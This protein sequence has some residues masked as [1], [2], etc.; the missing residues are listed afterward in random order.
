MVDRTPRRVNGLSLTD[1]LN[2]T[3]YFCAFPAQTSHTRT[4]PKSNIC[5]KGTSF[6]LLSHFIHFDDV[7]P[8]PEKFGS[9]GWVL[10]RCVRIISDESE[11]GLL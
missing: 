1:T 2:V 4:Q 6:D 3:V 5:A 9:S 11:E 8:Q 7:S 10:V